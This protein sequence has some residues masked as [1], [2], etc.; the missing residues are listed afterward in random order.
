MIDGTIA[1]LRD[2]GIAPERIHQGYFAATVPVSAPA[3]VSL[4]AYLD[5][6]EVTTTTDERTLV[7]R[8]SNARVRRPRRPAAPA[9]ARRVSHKS[10][11]GKPP[12]ARTERSAPLTWP[13][14]S[15]SPAKRSPRPHD[16]SSTTTP[17][18]DTPRERRSRARPKQAG[19]RQRQCDKAA[20]QPS[21][22]P[23]KDACSV[24]VRN[25]RFIG[26]E[27]S[28]CGEDCTIL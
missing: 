14:D 16:W 4:T 19:V 13:L 22:I 20:R 28:R 3:Q 5:G 18:S 25:L 15:C 9:P 23:A 11:K 10:S 24:G 2:L 8:P 21:G 26:Q 17:T 1:A 7:T 27:V 12:C 6:D